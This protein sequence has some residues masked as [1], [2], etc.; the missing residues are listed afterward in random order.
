[1][2]DGRVPNRFRVIMRILAMGARACPPCLAETVL[3]PA[4]RVARTPGP[5]SWS[6]L[7]QPPILLSS[8]SE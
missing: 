3:A 1:M 8:W 5:A 7:T 2:V 6:C 4:G